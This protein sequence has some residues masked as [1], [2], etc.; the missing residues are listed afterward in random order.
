MTIL[1]LKKAIE[2]ISD[3][4]TTEATTS[5]EETTTEA[6]KETVGETE[7]TTEASISETSGSSVTT[8]NEIIVAEMT[9][10]FTKI[11]NSD[12]PE[13]LKDVFRN[14]LKFQLN[15]S[16]PCYLRDAPYIADTF[17]KFAIIDFNKDGNNDVF[18]CSEYTDSVSETHR[19]I[20]SFDFESAESVFNI[21]STIK[22]DGIVVD[23]EDK[24]HFEY[25]YL[26]FNYEGSPLLTNAAKKTIGSSDNTIYLL[27]NKSAT[28]EQ[29]NKFLDSHKNAPDIQWIK[30]S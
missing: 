5:D 2:N 25:F 29:F 21:I 17:S 13:G 24:D 28:E 15:D 30:I 4:T 19:L 20:V 26:S 27:E 3:N 18:I 6:A 10:K 7:A 23:Y 14:K 8:K 11:I 16:S 1:L 9:D 22:S 12:I